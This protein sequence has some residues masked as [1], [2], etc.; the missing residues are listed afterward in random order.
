MQCVLPHLPLRSCLAGLGVVNPT[1]APSLL[2]ALCSGENPQ[3]LIPCS[4]ESDLCPTVSHVCVCIFLLLLRDT[5]SL[6]VRQEGQS[7]RTS[8]WRPSRSTHSKLCCSEDPPI[9]GPTQ[10]TLSPPGLRQGSEGRWRRPWNPPDGSGPG[11]L[12]GARWSRK[13]TRMRALSPGTER[14]RT[15]QRDGGWPATEAETNGAPGEH[16]R[17]EIL[18]NQDTAPKHYCCYH[19]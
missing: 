9:L 2:V 11:P 18:L 16:D 12:K 10:S 19:H 7:R 6:F 15:R 14:E 3:D 13:A 4:R 17:Q 1:T 8:V 5:L